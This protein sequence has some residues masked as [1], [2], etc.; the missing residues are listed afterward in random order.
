MDL[1]NTIKS[2]NLKVVISFG[3]YFGPNTSFY[4]IN[5][6]EQV[7]QFLD[8][9]IRNSEEDPDKRWIISLRTDMALGKTYRN[10]YLRATCI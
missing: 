8:T 6:K 4:G 9:K 1:L 2:N 10:D 5:R 3:K 7:V